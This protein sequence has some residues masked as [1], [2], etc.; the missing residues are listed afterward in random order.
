MS[1]QDIRVLMYEKV[2]QVFNYELGKIVQLFLLE[3]CKNKSLQSL[4]IK[5]VMWLGLQDNDAE[6]FD[7]MSASS[8]ITAGET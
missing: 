1:T 3:V 5:R 8:T 4:A 2:K 7:N 6:M